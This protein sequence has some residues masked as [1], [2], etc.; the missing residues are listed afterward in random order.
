MYHGWSDTSISP[1]NTI[2]YLEN[3]MSF[4]QGKGSR[5]D[6]EKS[7]QEFARLFMVPGMLHCSGGP[8]P[9]NFDM[10]AALETWVEKKQPPEQVMAS[11]STKGVIDR[12]R[13]LC[14]YPKV[15]RY[16]G[17]GSIDEA[18]NFSCDLPDRT[19]R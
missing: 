13:P 11:H 9:N 7:V 15:A 19:R 17:R 4:V 12:T 3:V 1:L 16:S 5:A 2:N 18:A 10:L 6:A 8:G 14:A